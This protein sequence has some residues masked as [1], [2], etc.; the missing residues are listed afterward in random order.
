[1]INQRSFYIPKDVTLIDAHGTDAAAHA[2]NNTPARLSV[3][4]TVQQAKLN[5]L[6]RNL[7]KE[8]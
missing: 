2:D 4:E 5:K 8:N 7:N 6:Y 1:M 3:R